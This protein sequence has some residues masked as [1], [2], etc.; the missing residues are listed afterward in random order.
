MGQTHCQSFLTRETTAFC[1]ILFIK[2]GC[3]HPVLVFVNGFDEVL[4]HFRNAH[5]VDDGMKSV[6]RQ[7]NL[8]VFDAADI[9][10]FLSKRL[11]QF[12]LS[13]SEFLT[14]VA[15]QTAKVRESFVEAAGIA[16]RILK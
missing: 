15:K 4:K 3:D 13:D 8:P 6:H 9:F 14:A 11:T 7:T 12:Q 16:L 5:E 10:A 2:A 1:Q